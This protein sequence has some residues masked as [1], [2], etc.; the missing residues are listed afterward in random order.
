[1]GRPE[2]PVDPEDGPVAR[3]ALG[4]RELR[5]NAGG[6]GYRELGRR[7]HYAATTLAQAARGMSLPSLPVTLAFVRACGGDVTGWE[8]R[9]RAT[10]AELDLDPHDIAEVATDVR[11]P[12]VGLGAY[13]PEDAEWFCGREHLVATLVERVT[14]ERFLTVVGASGAGK[15][16]VLRAGLLPGLSAAEQRWSTLVITPGARPLR[17]C[18]VR[19]GLSLDQLSEPHSL[20]M[21]IRQVMGARSDGAELV[22]IV[23]QFE[24]VFTLCQ[25]ER[26]RE[27]FIAALLDAAHDPDSRARVVLGLR[28]DF[29]AHCARHARLVDALQDAQVLVGPMSN[30]ELS[31]VITRPAVRAGLMVEKTLV[32]TLMHDAAERPGALP[33][34][35]HALWETWR[36]RRGNGLL[37]AGYR[38]A[39]GVHGAIAQ[40]ADHL[41]RDLDE[42][43]QRIAQGIMLRLTALGEGTEDTRRRV[44]RSELGTD[45]ATV[46]VVDRLA[47]ARL[48]TLAEDT[49]E[50]AHEAVIRSWPLLQSW[51]AMDRETV[52]VHR[53][54]TEAAAEWEG[55][56]REESLLYRGARLD[57]WRERALD[58]L[59][60]LERAFLAASRGVV[61][62]ERRSRRRRVRWT[63]GGLSSAIAIVAI[64]AV[65]SLVVA[66]RAEYNRA[67]AASRQLVTEARIQ[68]QTDPELGLLLA[69][70]AFTMAPNDAAEATLRQA[71]ADSHI[72][73]VLPKLGGAVCRVAF[74][75]D[76]G[77]LVSLDNE[78]T[79]RVWAMDDI[80]EV[81]R[82]APRKQDHPH[83]P[84]GGADPV[85]SADG[86]RIAATYGN[87]ELWLW[88]WTRDDAPLTRTELG[89]DWNDAIDPIVF[90]PDLDRV[91]AGN[92]YEG[93]RFW[94]GGVHD[95][96][97]ELRAGGERVYALKFSQDGKQLTSAEADGTVRVWDLA[98]GGSEIVRQGTAE[99]LEMPAISPD[100]RQMATGGRDGTVTV[101]D[102]AEGTSPVVL[103]SHDGYVYGPTYSADGHWIASF[104]VD[105]TVRIWNAHHRAAPA[106]LRA[107]HGTVRIALSPDGRT[108]VSVDGN[109]TAHVWAVDEVDILTVLRGQEESVSTLAVSADGRWVAASDQDGNLQV[110]DT[111]GGSPPVMLPT[112]DPRIHVFSVEKIPP[113]IFSPDGRFLVTKYPLRIWNVNDLTKPM[114]IPILQAD[115]L[116][117]SPDGKRFVV[118]TDTGAL[119]IWNTNGTGEIAQLP[120][121][122]RGSGA[123]LYNVAWSSDG[124][125]IAA[126][127]DG[128]AVLLW[129]LRTR[130]GPVVLPGGSRHFGSLTFSPD[131][132]QLASVRLDGTIHIWNVVIPADPVVLRGHQGGTWS[133]AFSVD[134]RQLVSTGNDATIRIWK[135]T[136]N[137]APLELNGFRASVEIV[138]SLDDGRYVSAHDDGTIRIWRCY[139]C[140]PIDDVLARVGQHVTRGLT[141]EERETYLSDS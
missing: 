120:T 17:E 39:G 82:S 113:A 83:C 129:D 79:L 95:S 36:R 72:R 30:D 134:S 24:E 35:S 10:A 85:F 12:Y 2:R 16:S 51:L 101:S 45:P 126:V 25:D 98:N 114:E 81:A 44:T 59:N 112:S 130:T 40:T 14:R 96:P 20:G 52:V 7:T 21:A 23:D 105:G 6:L 77:H 37:L 89:P 106:V 27:R 47:T 135:T 125:H 70:E 1:M 107:S 48:I 140:A 118:T 122:G 19:L 41:Y 57:S 102:I 38:A 46:E 99:P 63:T 100:G 29:Y 73:E 67:L 76:G 131:G 78:G 138:A 103:G 42:N 33:F 74:S 71:M 31:Q 54:L 49:V 80:R 117:F 121:G 133:V 115:S 127:T 66:A 26:E 93:I 88:D 11:V 3:F 28:A 64:L 60:D 56:G 18:A 69:R 136:G 110:W 119:S 132:T 4:L 94:P 61:E 15:S 53:R 32:T 84:G 139:A 123:E 55:Q 116:A 124:Q 13:G 108:V 141:P 92:R 97:I 34:V 137:A 50:M 109:G 86:S 58:R 43:Q 87:D 68:S 5:Q 90:S 22:L 104:G 62:Q 75:P 65:V 8:S 9:W 128:G 111:T 91:A